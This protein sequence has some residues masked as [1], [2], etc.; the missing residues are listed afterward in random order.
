MKSQRQK[1]NAAFTLIELLVVIAI[2]AILAALLLP[3]LVEAKKKANL[4]KCVSNQKQI[5][6]SYRLWMSDQPAEYGGAVPMRIAPPEGTLK[7]PLGGNAWYQYAWI[8]NEL[9]NPK[10]L[11]C[12]SDKTPGLKI[13]NT[14]GNLNADGGFT[15]SAYRGNS[16]SYT[17]NSDV[18]TVNNGGGTVFSE[19]AAQTQVLLSDFNFQPAA[20]GQG[21][22][23]L[24]LAVAVMVPDNATTNQVYWTNNVHKLRGNVTLLDG[25]V[26]TVA[27][28]LFVELVKKSDDNGSVHFL[29][30]H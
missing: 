15:G 27:N 1:A 21:C 16:I 26:Q 6:L 28:S 29:P 24:A 20:Y 25:S 12:P 10:I 17:L 9:S 11:V 3:A 19:L 2:I 22:S 30:A 5:V 13:A 14:F 8:S 4:I 23:A 7:A 18:G